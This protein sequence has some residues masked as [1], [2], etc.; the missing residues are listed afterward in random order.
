MEIY[1]GGTIFVLSAPSG[2]GKTTICEILIR[3]LPNLKMSISHTT[4]KPRTGERDGIDYFFID[5]EVF[6]TMIKNDDFIEWAE[7]YGNFYGTSK[8]IINELLQSGNDIL[9]DIDIQG[10]KNIKKTYPDSVLIFILPPSLEELEKRL[11]YRKEEID[12]IKMR[13]NKAKE[14]I[15]QYKIYDYLV[16]NDDLDKAVKEI[17]CIITAEK[18]KTNKVNQQIIKNF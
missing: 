10:A 13:L 16:V 1:K 14:E 2:T 18:L 4:R 12:T 6:E 3:S 8:K 15:S 7:V 11:K 5:K 17:L 9:L